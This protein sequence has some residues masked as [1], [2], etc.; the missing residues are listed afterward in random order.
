V[1][2][3]VQIGGEG[4]RLALER[5]QNVFGRMDSP[6]RPASAEEGFE[7]VRR[8]LFEPIMD[9]KLHTARDAVVRAFSDLYR[10]QLAEFPA[11]CREGAYERRLAAA[12]PIH[13]EVF[14]RLYNDWS[15]LDT[16]QRTRGVLRLMAA[17]IHT[18]WERDD[19]SLMILPASVPI[20]S[21]AVQTELTRYL[22]D[23]WVPVLESDVDGPHALPLAL[24]R[25]NPNLGR[26][27]ACRR[28]ARTVYIGSAP[29]LR[30][31]NRGLDDRHLKLGCAQPGESVAT[32]GDALRRLSSQ[33]TY[34]YTDGQRY[35]YDTHPSVTRLARDRATLLDHDL[36]LDA[37]KRRVREEQRS[38]EMFARVYPCPAS[39]AEIPDEREA[40]LIILS[41]EVPH[42]ARTED[43]PA[44]LAAAQMLDMRGTT[45]RRYRNA[46]AFL[47]ADRTRLDELEQAVRDYLAWQSIE[48]ER[49]TLNLDAFQTKQTQTKRQEAEETIRQRI[50]ETYQWLLVPEQTATDAPLTWR[51]IRLQGDGPLAVRAARKLVNDGLL[52]TEYAPSLLRLE[53]DRVP[54]W[55]GDHVKVQQLAE[56]FAQYLYLPRL[57]SPQLLVQAIEAG[58]RLLTWEHDTFAYA[59]LYDA[60]QARYRGLCA[61]RGGTVRLD[62]EAVLIQPVVARR[63]LD[64][65]APPVSAL[66]TTPL[67]GEIAHEADAEPYVP[68][69]PSRATLRPLPQPTRFYGT[70]PLDP[71]R[72]GREAG[73]IGEEVL[74]HLAGLLHAEVEVTL[75]IRAKVP[76]GVP[77]HVIRTVTENC[78]TLRFTTQEFEEA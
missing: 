40:R 54:L 39:S 74:Q 72:L 65:E 7:I 49:E 47:A 5:L 45:P 64:A 12:Y 78:R 63:Q 37:I 13:P 2:P 21:S 29:T 27:S 34:L 9:P 52:L 44:R 56:D 3:E 10:S 66:P 60:P 11:E 43:S 42:S 59:D 14:D 4:G 67:D 33:A 17:V 76:E 38:R 8:R 6:W 53:L 51:E 24:D 25:D 18:L 48:D 28:V 75:E 15:T 73:R 61:G 46:L 68:A 30:T 35:W 26:Y 71:L 50:P 41:P 69:A 31:A 62:A 58:L 23:P 77:E 1:L 32:F 22:E 16:F 19:R 36:V 55:R 57:C 20:D 70:V